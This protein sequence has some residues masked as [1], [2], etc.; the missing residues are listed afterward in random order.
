V[1]SPLVTVA[2]MV[3]GTLLTGIAA[4]TGA[5]VGLRRA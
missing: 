4:S 1:W 2:D 5:W 3:W